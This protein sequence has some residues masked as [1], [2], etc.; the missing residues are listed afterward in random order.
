M[1]TFGLLGHPLT[2]SFS[3][4]YFTNKFRDEHLDA[5]YLNFD[6]ENL[7]LFD[8]IFSDHPDLAGMNVT[9]PY[10]QQVISFLDALDPEAEAMGAVN[11]IRVVYRNGKRLL[12][13]YNSDFKGFEDSIRPLL[14]AGEALEALVLGT[15]GASKAVVYALR[16]LGVT[17]VY[18]SRNPVEGGFTYDELTPELLKRFRVIVN[19]TPVGMYPHVNEKPLLPY[20]GITASHI[21]Y[22]LIYNPEETAFL[23][24]ARRRGAVTCNGSKMLI[25]QALE[26]WRIWNLPDEL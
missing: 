19:T 21:C 23:A 25:G 22:D 20:E 14:P 6:L 12:I 11:V 16:R 1:K 13:G 24:E 5:Q 26:A 10:K 3:R 2:H 7:S 4:G 9:I 17:P 15:G 18:V 8:Q